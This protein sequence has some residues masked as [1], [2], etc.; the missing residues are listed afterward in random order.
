MSTET[1]EDIWYQVKSTKSVNLNKADFAKF[2]AFV[3]KHFPQAES[4]T[5][6]IRLLVNTDSLQISE[7]SLQGPLVG[8]TETVLRDEINSLKHQVT[9]LEHM[10][11]CEKEN[12]KD[13]EKVYTVLDKELD[14]VASLVCSNGFRNEIN[15][16]FKQ[17]FSD[18]ECPNLEYTDIIELVMDY[19]KADPAASALEIVKEHCFLPA[20]RE[21]IP[22]ELKNKLYDL[23]FPRP[24]IAKTV[25]ERLKAKAHESKE[26]QENKM[27]EQKEE[28]AVPNISTS[29]S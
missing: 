19:A 1:K 7:N 23:Q 17:L 13:A 5:D 22:A 16:A 27:E 8:N 21:K 12:V 9:A 29:I 24:E 10:L 26:A 28:T 20:D 6:F 4:F 3:A 15:I 25:Y 2:S 18:P 11:A 14:N